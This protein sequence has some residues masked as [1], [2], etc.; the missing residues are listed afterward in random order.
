MHASDRPTAAGQGS[1]DPVAFNIDDV[2]ARVADAVE[3]AALDK[4]LEL[5]VHRSREVPALLVGDPLRLGQV[6][7]HL[8]S[9]AVKFTTRGEVSIAIERERLDE[10][11]GKVMLRFSVTDTGI[12]LSDEIAKLFL[13]FN[14]HDASVER[15]PQG[16]N[17]GLATVKEW[18]ESMRGRIETAS[19]PDVGTDIS[20]TAC[21][22]LAPE[23]AANPVE[24]PPDFG[25][26]RVLVL[27]DNDTARHAVQHM[28]ETAGCRTG[29]A[30]NC[31]E[32]IKELRDAAAHAAPYQL[33]MI[34]WQLPDMD[35]VDAA[36]LIGAAGVPPLHLI[37]MVTEQRRNDITA[38]AGHLAT[39]LDAYLPKPVKARELNRI[40]GNVIRLSKR[41]AVARSGASTDALAAV[42]LIDMQSALDRLGQNGEL[43]ERFLADFCANE[44][45]CAK[46]VEQLFLAGRFA[47]ART[48]VH[49][50]KGTAMVLG[51]ERLATAATALEKALRHSDFA[52][53]QDLFPVFASEVA[54]AA[55]A[56]ALESERLRAVKADEARSAAPPA[57][58]DGV[59]PL[60]DQLAAL[61]DRNSMAAL[62]IAQQLVRLLR[63]TR[64]D[65][66]AAIMDSR[67]HQLDFAGARDQFRQ[68]RDAFTRFAD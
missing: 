7:L 45:G 62:D 31:A 23:T 63:G 40:V 64:H 2:L 27:D 1:P 38:R 56:C 8:S 60:L 18:V 57:P 54:M 26:L 61:L 39:Q 25:G 34:D 4:G 58:P 68:L 59:Q 42:P 52:A 22:G 6:L 51:L 41:V 15:N 17:F 44:A 47:D 53:S 49:T 10:A 19:A 5:V 48:R 32:A 50:V 14:H 46:D 33:A 35:C 67:L 37:V 16:K 13:P 21:F 30:S 28:L 29:V 11:A 9:N 24:A 3:T 66:V 43:L 55:A 65:G 20:F 12:G 36:R